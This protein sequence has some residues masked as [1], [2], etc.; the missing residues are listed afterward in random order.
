MSEHHLL[1]QGTTPPS[2]QY[3]SVRRISVPAATAHDAPST[4]N[5]PT[6]SLPAS[7]DANDEYSPNTVDSSEHGSSLG[8]RSPLEPSSQSRAAYGKIACQECVSTKSL[9]RGD[10]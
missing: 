5:D 4:G 2:A 7:Q 10:V 1:S 3:T 9:R 8:H 6:F